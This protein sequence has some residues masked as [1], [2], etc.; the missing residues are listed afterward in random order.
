MYSCNM[1]QLEAHFNIFRYL[2][3]KVLM[4][5]GDRRVCFQIFFPL[6][7][8]VPLRALE[9]EFPSRGLRLEP[10]VVHYIVYV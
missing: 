2:H 5:V 1:V 7:L 3:V 4:G 9:D 10:T 6:V 8:T